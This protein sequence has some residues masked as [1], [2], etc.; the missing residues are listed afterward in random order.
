MPN[1]GFIVQNGVFSSIVPPGAS[2]TFA[3]GLNDSDQVVGDF[4]D[5]SNVFHGF[6]RDSNGAI[7]TLDVPFA[8]ATATL[9]YDINNYGVIVGQYTGYHGFVHGFIYFQG[10]F[11]SFNY[12]GSVQTSIRGIN[13]KG[14]ITG[15]Y[16]DKSGVQHG[17]L[18]LARRHQ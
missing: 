10:Q 7:S 13:N 12:P 18:A 6:F 15:Y 8:G 14:D 17:F 4:Q 3:L 11:T 9:A 1:E 2:S 16:I 5:A